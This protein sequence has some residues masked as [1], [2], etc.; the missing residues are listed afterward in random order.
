MRSYGA[1]PRVLADDLLVVAYGDRHERSFRDAFS[2]THKYL[3]DM[4]AKVSVSKSQVFSRNRV[5][6]RRLREHRWPHLGQTI[7]LAFSMRD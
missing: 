3:T 1:V 7:K 5:A 6:R 4:G 2:A